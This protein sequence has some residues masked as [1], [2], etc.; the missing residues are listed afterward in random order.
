MF[1]HRLHVPQC[2]LLPLTWVSKVPAACAGV[3]AGIDPP[4]LRAVPKALVAC[5]QV[6]SAACSNAN[7]TGPYYCHNHRHTSSRAGWLVLQVSR[8]III[9]A[10]AA[11]AAFCCCCRCLR[12]QDR[13][14]NYIQFY[15]LTLT[16]APKVS[17]HIASIAAK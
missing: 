10:A 4:R 11:A 3:I 2:L 5:T 15:K 8:S 12:N 1:H 9:A 16:S 14:Q 6:T 13:Q 17:T 7:V